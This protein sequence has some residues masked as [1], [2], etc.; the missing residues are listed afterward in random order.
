M[1]KPQPQRTFEKLADEGAES[2]DLYSDELHRLATG[3]AAL[4]KTNEASLNDIELKAVL[5]LISYVAHTQSV[6]EAVV[7]EVLTSHFGINA[8]AELPSRLYQNAIEYLVD[9]KMDN[10]VN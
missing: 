6:G 2:I 4:R 9:L 3:L 1:A 10:V 8:V 7:G 5:G